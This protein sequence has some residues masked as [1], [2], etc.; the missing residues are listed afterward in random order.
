[1]KTAVFIIAE[2]IFRDE[3][4]LV[5]KDILEQAGIQVITASTV[6]DEA[7]GKL[8][9][10]VVPDILIQDVDIDILD[11]VIFIG[12][13]GAAQ[14]FDDSLAHQLASSAAKLG[15]VVGAICIAPVI[16]ANANLLKDK[17]ATVFPDGSDVLIQQGAIYTG[18][19]VE[20]DGNIITGNGPEAAQEF[21]EKLVSLLHL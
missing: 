5:P 1:M 10:K 9:L 11:G 15:K 19:P 21:G 20:I 7:I 17:T 6:T 14:Y 12:G 8:G 13:G 4:Y 16:L 18:N 2:K 3:E